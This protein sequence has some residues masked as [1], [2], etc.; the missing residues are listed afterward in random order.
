MQPPPTP[1]TPATAASSLRPSP[2][3]LAVVSPSRSPRP[4]TGAAATSQPSAGEASRYLRVR[5]RLAHPHSRL[6][7]LHKHPHAHTHTCARK[8]VFTQTRA[9]TPAAPRPWRHGAPSARP[10]PPAS[11][12]RS[13]TDGLCRRA[14]RC[15]G[16]SRWVLEAAAVPRKG[17]HIHTYTQTH[18]MYKP[19]LGPWRSGQKGGSSC[20]GVDKLAAQPPLPLPAHDCFARNRPPRNLARH[21]R[22]AGSRTAVVLTRL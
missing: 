13:S 9:D 7:C 14:T 19:A 6:T 10:P 8:N 20:G 21:Q 12:R 17:R 5:P 3:S 4:A 15:S 16:S 18:A 2:R 22:L 1:A 11:C